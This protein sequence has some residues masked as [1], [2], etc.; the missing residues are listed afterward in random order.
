MA[1]Y[2]YLCKNCDAELKDVRQSIKDR[3][4]TACDVC[5][6]HGLERVIF[7]PQVFVRGE[8]STIGQLAERNSK[9]I[10]KY[11]AQERSLKDKDLKKKALGEAKKE[12][13]SKLNSMSE[14]QKQRYIE[15]GRT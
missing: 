7:P 14:S 1:V 11:E 4:L 9:K 2:D 3:P 13:R 15:D 6:T 10:G 8:A 5:K 12:M